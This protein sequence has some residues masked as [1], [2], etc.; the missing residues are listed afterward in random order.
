LVS[1][2][3]RDLLPG[4]GLKF[5]ERGTAGFVV[6]ARTLASLFGGFGFRLRIDPEFHPDMSKPLGISEPA[7]AHHRPQRGQAGLGEEQAR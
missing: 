1:R 7:V 5:F 6:N 4:A 2:V 3:V